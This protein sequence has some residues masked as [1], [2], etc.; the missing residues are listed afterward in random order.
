MKVETRPLIALEKLRFHDCEPYGLASNNRL[1]VRR[2]FSLGAY[3]YTPREAAGA[4]IVRSEEAQDAD[5]LGF[6]A[7]QNPGTICAVSHT[8]VPVFADVFAAHLAYEVV[9][10]EPG[11]PRWLAL[12]DVKID[13]VDRSQ[14]YLRVKDATILVIQGARASLYPEALD[15]L[16][17]LLHFFEHIPI[18]YTVHDADA[19]SFWSNVLGV[20]PSHVLH[21]DAQQHQMRK[22]AN[23]ARAQK[24]GS[25]KIE[26]V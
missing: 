7:S 10:K 6:L 8:N 13:Q 5:Y 24:V 18:V 20:R 1:P 9:R 2:T 22:A 16:R 4:S 12:S 17:A 21:L 11:R 14:A 19:S 3:A 15:R 26:E 25:R 23:V